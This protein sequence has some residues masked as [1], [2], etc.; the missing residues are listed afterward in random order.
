[1]KRAIEIAKVF[2]NSQEQDNE[3]K[4]HILASTLMGIIN[5]SDTSPS[6]ADKMKAIISHF[7]TQEIGMDSVIQGKR[8]RQA[9]AISYGQM[10]DEELVISYL[11]RYIKPDLLQNMI[12]GKM[13]PYSLEEFGLAVEFATLYEGSI[14]S[15]RIQEYTATLMTRL[16]TIQEGI[17][18]K[19]LSKTEYTSIDKYIDSMLGE[20]LVFGSAINLPALTKFE[21]ASPKTDSDNAKISEKWY[22][23]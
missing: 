3:L 14:S 6:K 18:G 21:Q 8:L 7:G 22:V 16:Q 9:I 15:Q 1:M 10:P 20:T 13:V 23:D 2:Y 17:Q 12:S 4:N 5:S 19:L 11:T